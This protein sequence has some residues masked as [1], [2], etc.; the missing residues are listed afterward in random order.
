MAIQHGETVHC[1][2]ESSSRKYF[3]FL[4]ECAL[5]GDEIIKVQ[6]IKLKCLILTNISPKTYLCIRTYIAL[7]VRVDK[8]TEKTLQ[9]TNNLAQFLHFYNLYFDEMATSHVIS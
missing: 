9:S 1:S 4:K 3:V 7:L 2:K 6:V 5:S 8:T